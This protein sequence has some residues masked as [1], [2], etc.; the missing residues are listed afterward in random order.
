MAP[1]NGQSYNSCSCSKSDAHAQ[2]ELRRGGSIL[3][4]LI[5]TIMAVRKQVQHMY[6]V[7]EGPDGSHPG[8]VG[9]KGDV[10]LADSQGFG[11][12]IEKV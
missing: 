9:K 8:A 6:A 2:D 3:I 10:A 1:V 11:G 4:A 12:T 7:R 5:V